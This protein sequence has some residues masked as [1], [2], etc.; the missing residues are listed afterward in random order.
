MAYII[1]DSVLGK[2]SYG[3]VYLAS[4]N[5]KQIAVKCCHMYDNGIEN[6]IET[7]LMASLVHPNIN[8]ALDIFCTPETVYIIQELAMMDLYAYTNINKQNHHCS[9]EELQ[10]IFYSITQAVSILHQHQFIHADIKSNNIL[11]FPNNIIK[12]TDFTLTVRKLHSSTKYNNTVCTPTHRPIEC[13]M[14][15]SWDESLD[16]W[17]LGCTFYEIAYNE[18]LF[19][20]QS[21]IDKSRYDK[22]EQKEVIR[23]RYV[24]AIIHWAEI[25]NQEHPYKS[26]D[27]KYDPNSTKNNILPLVTQILHIDAKQRP[28][29][30]EIINSPMFFNFTT[31]VKP[32][33]NTHIQNTLSM[34][35][36]ARVIRY[37][38]QCTNNDAVQ[39][40]A[41]KIYTQLTLDTIGEYNKAIGC[42]WLACKMINTIDHFTKL[43]PL[44]DILYTEREILHNL[45][46]CLY[47]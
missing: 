34:M 24:N 8:P 43:I 35:E 33:L 10:H 3:S 20:N 39:S 44:E 26:Y 28:T 15:Q 7:S 30:T 13:H 4:K 5:D 2:G 37:I 12:L 27:I 47:F 36:E 14:K 38:E 6:I 9:Y 25:Q 40:L 21:Y 11:L 19:V 18:P 46:F 41:Y 29:I 31:S 32:H 16:I 23:Q 17:S 22:K 42:A 1:N 45:H